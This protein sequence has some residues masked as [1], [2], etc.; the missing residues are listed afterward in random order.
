MSPFAP[1]VYSLVVTNRGSMDVRTLAIGDVDDY[2]RHM[3]AV[4]AGSGVDGEAHSHPYSASEPFDIDA[5]RDREVIRWS[6]G[7]DELGWR[8]AW[9]L[10]DA[11]ELVGHLYLAG[12][13][14]RSE[15]HRVNLGMGI[16]SSHRRQG[17]GRML[18]VSAI[19]WARKQAIIAW[20]DLGVFSDNPGAQA[21]YARHGFEVLG[22]TPDRFRVDGHSLDDISMTL[23]V[24]SHDGSGR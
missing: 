17:G 16:Q 9:G 24:A 22:S 12:G 6:T 4:D 2:L 20:I 19:E 10:F 3:R 5:A 13:M 8:R 15:L 11:A 7:I 14:L 21:L 1:V 18:L 23:N